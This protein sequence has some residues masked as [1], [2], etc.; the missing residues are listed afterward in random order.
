MKHLLDLV[1]QDQKARL[2]TICWK[3]TTITAGAGATDSGID[4]LTGVRGLPDDA[5]T[6]EL[7][8]SCTTSDTEGLEP[9]AAGVSC[10]EPA[11]QTKGCICGHV[12]S[13]LLARGVNTWPQESEG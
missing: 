5:T 2:R 12:N 7:S 10:P 6:G 3:F 1:R 13:L 9:A 4:P 8:R 11:Y